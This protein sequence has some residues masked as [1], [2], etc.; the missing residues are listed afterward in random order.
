[1]KK[2]VVTIILSLVF[3]ALVGITGF[4]GYQFYKEFQII[5]AHDAAIKQIVDFINK[6]IPAAQAPAPEPTK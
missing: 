5:N 4:L 1:M 2:T 3:G 6:N